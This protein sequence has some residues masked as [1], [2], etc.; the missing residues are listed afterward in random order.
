MRTG[1]SYRRRAAGLALLSLAGLAAVWLR[2]SPEPSGELIT[3]TFTHPK[4]PRYAFLSRLISEFEA[5]NPG[6]R[7]REQVLPAATDE[8]HQFYILNLP[9]RTGDFDVIDMDI[10]WVPEFARAGWLL[11]LTPHISETELAPLHGRAL[12][13]DRMDGRLYALPW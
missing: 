10:I 13:A 4:H 9:A 11:E 3:L 5:E 6:V 1:S 7:V 12:Q 2:P 8:Q